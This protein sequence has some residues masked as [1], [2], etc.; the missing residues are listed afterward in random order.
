MLS[1]QVLLRSHLR[2]IGYAKGAT[3]AFSVTADRVIIH[4]VT[5]AGLR[6]HY[7]GKAMIELLCLL[8][9]AIALRL[10]WI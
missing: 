1:D 3:I 5:G 7:A 9:R 4:G 10:K 6:F 2:I 8:E